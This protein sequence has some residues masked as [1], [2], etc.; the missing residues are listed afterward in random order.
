[1]GT[2]R[3]KTYALNSH[4]WPALKQQLQPTTHWCG[5]S[6]VCSDTNNSAATTVCPQA[7][8]LSAVQPAADCGLQEPG[9]QGGEAASGTV[10]LW[11]PWTRGDADEGTPSFELGCVIILFNITQV[12]VQYI[13]LLLT[14]KKRVTLKTVK[15]QKMYNYTRQQIYQPAD[16]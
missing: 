9:G 3:L 2:H 4:L 11:E 10:W 6:L 15:Q 5:S 8:H 13:F 16:K 7:W 12:T 14:C 1:M